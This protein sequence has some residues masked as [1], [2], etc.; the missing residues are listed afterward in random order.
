MMMNEIETFDLSVDDFIFN[1]NQS[2]EF[3]FFLLV[4][5]YIDDN[6]WS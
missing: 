2:F 5:S 6:Q 3:G 1:V 4:R